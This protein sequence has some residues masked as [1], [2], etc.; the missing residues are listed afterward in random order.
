M[1]L[2]NET[3]KSAILKRLNRIEGQVRGISGMILADR[4][5]TEIIQQF[6]AVRSATQGAMNAFLEEYAAAC[7]RRNS[8]A[9]P[10]E[11]EELMQNL[12]SL[13][14]KAV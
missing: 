11:R 6:T 10:A 1:K 9:S 7:L 14:N 4:D 2:E 12:L 3:S 5:C 13:L 8:E